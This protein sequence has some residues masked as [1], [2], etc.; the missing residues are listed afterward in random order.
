MVS[1]VKQLFLLPY[2]KLRRGSL[3]EELGQIALA[4]IAD[5]IGECGAREPPADENWFGLSVSLLPV[6]GLLRRLVKH[7]LRLN[8]L[9]KKKGNRH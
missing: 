8:V 3:Q 4:Y 9:Y 7:E 2:C 6:P 1:Q 5:R